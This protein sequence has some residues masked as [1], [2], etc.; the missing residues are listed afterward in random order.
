MDIRNKTGLRIRE[1]RKKNRITQQQLS[2][3]TLLDKSYLSETENGKRNLSL[4]NLEKIVK[5]LDCDLS[6][7]FNNELFYNEQKDNF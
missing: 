3:I 7:F 6:I 1:L 2:D 4:I 5:A